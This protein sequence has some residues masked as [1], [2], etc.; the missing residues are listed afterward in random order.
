MD[1]RAQRVWTTLV[2]MFGQPLLNNYGP[3]PPPVWAAKI[4]EL[5]E[6]QLG[7]GLR[8]LSEKPTPYPP[9]LG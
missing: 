8:T 4:S 2:E 3:E 9:T 7:N 6:A 5:S 1:D